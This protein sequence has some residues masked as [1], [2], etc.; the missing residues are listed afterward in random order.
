[1]TEALRKNCSG[2]TLD[3]NCRLMAEPGTKTVNINDL[4]AI[5][6]SKDESLLTKNAWMFEGELFKFLDG[7]KIPEGNKIAFNTFPRSGNTLLRR[8]LEQVTGIATGSNMPLL[9]T[10]KQ[11]A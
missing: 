9:K 11:Q 1:M 3:K 2:Y 10:S 5:L 7:S 4:I 8:C 6:K